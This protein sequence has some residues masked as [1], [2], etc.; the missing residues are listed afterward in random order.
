[1]AASLSDVVDLSGVDPMKDTLVAATPDQASGNELD[2]KLDRLKA[3]LDSA[4]TQLA[5]LAAAVAASG[6]T[7]AP[8][9]TL[10]RPTARS[11]AGLRSGAYVVIDPRARDLGA[12]S[13]V[14]T[15]DAESLQLAFDAG[16]GRQTVALHENGPCAYSVADDGESSARILVSRSGVL[17]VRTLSTSGE[18]QGK[19][20]ARVAIPVQQ[21][22]LQE[23]AGRWN[24]MD[25]SRE[26]DP[27]L[28]PDG[29]PYPST[30][31]TPFEAHFGEI[32]FDDTGAATSGQGCD[33]AR[34]C[35]ALDLA[36]SPV[37]IRTNPAGG[38]D[39]GAG[40][41]APA[42]A[43]AFKTADGHVSIFAINPGARGLSVLTRQS[44]LT[45]PQPDA[46]LTFWDFVLNTAGDAL[47][48][49]DF[50]VRYASVDAAAG[51]YTRLRPTD[52]R[53]DTWT[54]NRPLP[55]LRVRETD[56]CTVGDRPVRCV[57]A[58]ALPLAGTGV[59]FYL[60]L[61]PSD[62]FGFAVNR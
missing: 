58:I 16:T 7:D 28:S 17:L 51:T 21:I 33:N 29:L 4:R 1:V 44:P 37:R 45:L 2:R 5:E 11:C 9:R 38:F 35:D 6:N 46:T 52:N 20:Q 3:A 56:A 18:D 10:L 25:Y 32:A 53:L 49:A 40:D 36:A 14:V 34:R 13:R 50:T 41:E 55:G 27:A 60:A 61:A 8:V 12:A 24:W 15:I 30:R 59:T 31:Y 39:L 43:F 19:T 23:L 22:P 62:M 57:G 42:R 47:G 26:T 48:L 54:I